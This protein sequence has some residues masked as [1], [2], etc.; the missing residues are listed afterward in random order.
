LITAH[1][2]DTNSLKLKVTFESGKTV[3]NNL[4]I[5]LLP[6]IKANEKLIKRS[7]VYEIGCDPKIA[8]AKGKKTAEFANGLY[9]F[10]DVPP[11]KY[12]LKVCAYYGGYQEYTK[13]KN[14]NVTINF[15]AS[16]PIR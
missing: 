3:P 10:Y 12:F 11:G 7:S 14:G 8:D 16:P 2:E 1:P 13:A 6:E 5:Y 9:V 4:L 15:D